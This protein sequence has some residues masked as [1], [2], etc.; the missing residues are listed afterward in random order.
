MVKLV[1]MT[2]HPI[3]INGITYQPEGDV[4]RLAEIREAPIQL[5]GL[6]LNRI[7]VGIVVG[8]PKPSDCFLVVSREVARATHRPD[9]V[10]VCDYIRDE[11]GRIIGASSI[12]WFPPDDISAEALLVDDN[13]N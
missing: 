11:Q 12:A 3:T 6:V 13:K 2:P 8:L 5:D 1:N 4:P 9:V 10:S 7:F